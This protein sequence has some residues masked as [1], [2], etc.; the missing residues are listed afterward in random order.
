M[1]RRLDKWQKS[2]FL[3][4]CLFWEY[5]FGVR[6]EIL[7][8]KDHL[9]TAMYWASIQILPLDRGE[10]LSCALGW[11]DE[12]QMYLTPDSTEKHIECC[13]WIKIQ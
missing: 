3:T 6:C 13:F 9:L 1:T 7:S 4:L 10:L 8:S 2:R 5:H 12:T 11:V